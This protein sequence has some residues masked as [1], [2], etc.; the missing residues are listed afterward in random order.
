MAEQEFFEVFVDAPLEVVE[1]RDVKGLYLKARLGELKNF[2]GIDSPYERPLDP[3]IHI[4]TT[5]ETIDTA[6]KKIF[7]YLLDND[8]LA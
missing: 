2:T 1:R 4:D 3:H 8:K 5:M 7:Q 6:A